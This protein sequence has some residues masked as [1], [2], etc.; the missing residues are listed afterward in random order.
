MYIDCAF[1]VRARCVAQ[2]VC[3]LR[4]GGRAQAVTC[5][6]VRAVGSAV[7]T[8]EGSDCARSSVPS[9][10]SPDHWC[11]YSH[12]DLEA[13]DLFATWQPCWLKKCSG[14]VEMSSWT[15]LKLSAP[16][17]SCRSA[18][19]SFEDHTLCRALRSS[20]ILSETHHGVRIQTSPRSC[21][22]W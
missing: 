18:C 19:T 6:G 7:A 21:V 2:P 9:A 13:E 22:V 11:R 5:F 15:Q 10:C 8:P 12:K 16:G 14:P 3:V 1:V 4:Y 17:D 20:V